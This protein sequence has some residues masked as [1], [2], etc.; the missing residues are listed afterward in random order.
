MPLALWVIALAALLA[1]TQF[2]VFAI[3]PGLSLHLASTSRRLTLLALYQ[4]TVCTMS[5]G[6]SSLH[7]L[8]I[9][10]MA[11][12]VIEIKGFFIVDLVN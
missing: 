12:K 3:S 9:E 5:T 11:T 4:S 1:L 7:P 6:F 8:R 2:G 10:R